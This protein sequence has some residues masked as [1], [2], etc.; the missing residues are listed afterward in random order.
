MDIAPNPPTR[1]TTVV[2]DTFLTPHLLRVGFEMSLRLVALALRMGHD[3]APQSAFCRVFLQK[4]TKNL[5]SNAQCHLIQSPFALA[6]CSTLL[7]RLS[8]A[9]RPRS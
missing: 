5:Y 1:R 4:E 8:H 3:L 7:L 2:E 9:L 6:L